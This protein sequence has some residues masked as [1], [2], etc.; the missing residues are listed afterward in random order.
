[1]SLKSLANHYLHPLHV[2]F[3]VSTTC[4]AKF[5]KIYTLRVLL[6]KNISTLTS[7]AK[8][9]TN[10][11]QYSILHFTKT[12]TGREQLIRSHSLARFCFELSGNL[13]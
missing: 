12:N 7:K 3:S 2:V 9:T 6:V 10:I 13:N 1:M 11:A 8:F 4:E 5:I